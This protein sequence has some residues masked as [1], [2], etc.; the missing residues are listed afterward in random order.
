MEKAKGGLDYLHCESLIISQMQPPAC[1]ATIDDCVSWSGASS[2]QGVVYRDIFFHHPLDLRLCLSRGLLHL[3]PALPE[4]LL[5]L[6]LIYNRR[7]RAGE[8]RRTTLAP[9]EFCSILY[10]YAAYAQRGS[11]AGRNVK[12][13]HLKVQVDS[14]SEAT[15]FSTLW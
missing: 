10:G 2:R 13:H 14:F 6:R 8:C 4:R 12:P 3:F 9:L 11:L 7:V 15:P 1:L 5:G